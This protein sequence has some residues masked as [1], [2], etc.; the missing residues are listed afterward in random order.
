MCLMCAYTVFFS[1]RHWG[2]SQ[3]SRFQA[4]RRILDNI[5]PQ[6]TALSAFL[7]WLFVFLSVEMVSG[8]RVR[9]IS[10]YNI[11]LD[12]RFEW[13]I[14]SSWKTSFAFASSFSK[15]TP[16]EHTFG[17]EL[18]ALLRKMST[19]ELRFSELETKIARALPPCLLSVL[20]TAKRQRFE[21]LL[22]FSNFV[23]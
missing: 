7:H 20:I 8:L 1:P 22:K 19:I 14:E 3:K 12:A 6:T 21:N 11:F 18:Q 13:K 2:R 4:V 23:W 15:V 9:L 5:V 17:G 16:W 10:T